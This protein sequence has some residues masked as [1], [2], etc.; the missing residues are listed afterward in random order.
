M[1]TLL[2]D[3]QGLEGG[4]CFPNVWVILSSRQT[5]Y[6]PSN[7]IMNRQNHANKTDIRNSHVYVY[8]V[9]ATTGKLSAH[10]Y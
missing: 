8:I 5:G 1:N 3:S 9:K 10:A 4:I 2:V 7:I 6:I